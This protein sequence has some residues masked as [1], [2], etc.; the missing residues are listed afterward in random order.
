MLARALRSM[1]TRPYFRQRAASHSVGRDRWLATDPPGPTDPISD[2]VLNIPDPHDSS[3]HPLAVLGDD[4]MSDAQQYWR[5][6]AAAMPPPLRER[7][8]DKLGRAYAT[9]KRKCSVACVWVTKGNGEIK[10]N[11]RN[12]VDIFHRVDH[13][14]QVLRPLVISGVLGQ[15]SVVSTVRGGGNTG[16]AE[17][18]RH[19]IAKALQ[20]YDPEFRPPLKKDG[21]LTRDSRVVESKK[22]GRKKARKSFQWVKR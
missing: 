4:D 21:L 18:L 3:Q 9:G 10:V 19:G 8:V 20:L 13:R 6:R 7:R 15:F 1:Q 2:E 17:A 22:Y 14:D 11:G 5:Q 16:Q 12:Y